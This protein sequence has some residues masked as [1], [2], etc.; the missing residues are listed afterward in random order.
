MIELCCK[1]LMS[2][3][4]FRVNLH[5]IVAW[6]SRNSLPEKGVISEAWVTVSTKKF[7]DIQATIERTFTPKRLGDMIMTYSRMCH[8][9]RFYQ[10]R[11]IIWP[12]RLNGC[13]FRLQSNWLWVRIPF[14]PVK[15]QIL[16]LLWPRG[17]LTFSQL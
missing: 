13:V 12:V 16:R 5:S 7:L 3:T 4:L 9:D 2:R 17:S 14:L 8:T 1:Y 10:H 6:M 11:S 15:L